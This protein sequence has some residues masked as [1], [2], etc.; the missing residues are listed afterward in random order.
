MKRICTTYF[1]KWVE[2]NLRKLDNRKISDQLNVLE[3]K[4]TFIVL[5]PKLQ[6]IGLHFIFAMSLKFHIL[7]SWRQPFLQNM[8]GLIEE[9]KNPSPCLNPWV[10]WKISRIGAS[11]LFNITYNLQKQQEMWSI[12]FSFG[13]YIWSRIHI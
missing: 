1:S 5:K 6:S 4:H 10:W 12:N 9:T 2:H 7:S 11:V 8:A 13:L 3:T